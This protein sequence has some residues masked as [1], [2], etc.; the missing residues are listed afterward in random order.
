MDPE[1]YSADSW[2]LETETDRQRSAALLYKAR[3]YR[4]YTDY[5]QIQQWFSRHFFQ[6][7]RLEDSPFQLFDQRSTL[8]ILFCLQELSVKQ[9]TDSSPWQPICSQGSY[10]SWDHL[11]FGLR[12]LVCSRTICKWEDHWSWT[13]S[14]PEETLSKVNIM[15]VLSLSLPIV[16]V[17]LRLEIQVPG[18]L[19][20]TGCVA[21]TISCV[22]CPAQIHE[23]LER[24][25]AVYAMS[26]ACASTSAHSHLALLP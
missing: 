25:A 9:V 19:T 21:A 8:Y 3:S 4:L 22:I 23:R 1:I 26:K 20:G 16:S 13:Q 14:K 15:K 2:A 12:D 11:K 24:C 18:L 17:C 7:R 10:C 6:P 5:I